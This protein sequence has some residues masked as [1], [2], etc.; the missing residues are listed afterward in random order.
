M[1]LVL[2]RIVIVRPAIPCVGSK[3]KREETSVI[4]LK[5]SYIDTFITTATY[6][7]VD[8]GRDHDRLSFVDNPS[9]YYK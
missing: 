7:Q 3:I 1:Y 4:I 6:N 5:L 2:G 8:K 9:A